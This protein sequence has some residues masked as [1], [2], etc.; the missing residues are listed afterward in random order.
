MGSRQ[1]TPWTGLQSSTGHI[2]TRTLG[3]CTGSQLTYHYVFGLWE[4]TR[5]SGGNPQEHGE[6]TQAPCRQRETVL[7]EHNCC[8]SS[9]ATTCLLLK[10]HSSGIHSVSTAD[11]ESQYLASMTAASP[12]F[13]A[14]LSVKP[15]SSGIHSVSTAG[16]SPPGS[17]EVWLCSRNLNPPMS[18]RWLCSFCTVLNKLWYAP[19]VASSLVA[20]FAALCAEEEPGQESQVE[21]RGRE[22]GKGWLLPK[23]GDSQNLGPFLGE[24]SPSPSPALCPPPVS[25]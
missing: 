16:L 7:D 25:P 19:F 2:H 22:M 1:G 4:E 15:H 10:P 6:K 3:Q 14:C 24:A 18:Q 23:Q 8:K 5:A 9:F 17:A 11:P 21:G 20:G 12:V 13:Q